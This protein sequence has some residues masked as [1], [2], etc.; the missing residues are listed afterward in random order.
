MNPPPKHATASVF[1]FTPTPDGWRIGL[2]HHPRFQRWM[3]PGGHV[4]AH[5]N[6]SEAALREV[7][8]E[9]GLQAC[10][11]SPPGLGDPPGAD[12]PTVPAPI[13]VVEQRV[14]PER[15][16]PADHVHID[17]LYLALGPQADVPDDAELRFVWFA[18]DDL[19]TL[20]MFT[21]T[22]VRAR[23]LFLRLAEPSGPLTLARGRADFGLSLP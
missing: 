7:K 16:E 18:D 19:D 12:D 2:V 9:T 5:E 22:R 23:H 15:R 14:P 17:H 8:E 3:L 10:L 13:W 20:R 21:D 1:L 4:E 6:P 11:L